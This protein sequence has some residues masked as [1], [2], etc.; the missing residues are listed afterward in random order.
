MA[1]KF[2]KH[3]VVDTETGKKA[4]VHYNNSVLTDGRECVTLYAKDYNRDLA[5]IFAGL[6]EN[7]T[8]TMTDY[9]ETGKVRI[10][11]GHPLHAAAS[12]RAAA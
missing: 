9:F 6:Y 8:D 1:I 11:P 3:N 4:R 12:E 7:E 10:F 5:E 2:N